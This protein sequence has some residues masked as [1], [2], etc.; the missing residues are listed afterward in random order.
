MAKHK[1]LAPMSGND[2]DKSPE[3]EEQLEDF[4]LYEQRVKQLMAMT[5]DGRAPLAEAFLQL[6][7]A[8]QC[9]V[10]LTDTKLDIAGSGAAIGTSPPAFPEIPGKAT[11]ARAIAGLL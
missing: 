5:M 4:Q 7:F 3:E 2:D 1:T 9:F 10:E 6:G 11:K 8:S